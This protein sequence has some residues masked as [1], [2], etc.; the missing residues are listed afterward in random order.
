MPID[1]T[2]GKEVLIAA[3]AITDPIARSAF[4][5]RQCDAELRSWVDELLR[6]SANPASGIA[7]SA[8]SP[9]A[10]TEPD[11]TILRPPESPTLTFSP[12]A[13][14]TQ[15]LF[16]KSPGSADEFSPTRT[17]SGAPPNIEGSGANRG[18]IAG[19]YR[20]VE[21]IGQGGMGSVYLARQ[22]T[23][24]KRDVALKLIKKGADSRAVVARFEAER[25]ALALMDH[26]NIAS[27]YDGG[28]T[29]DG[30]P[31]FVMELV[32]GKPITEYCDDHRLTLS[33]R[34][35]L[36]VQVCRAVQHAHQKGIIHRDLKPGNIL[37]TEVD[38]RPTPKVIDFG[39]AKA[40]DQRL[41]DSSFSDEGAIVGTPA[42]MSP[43]QTDPTGVDI[44]T[45]TDV[46]ALGVVL[47]ELLAGSPPISMKDFRRG[48]ILEML[49]M[50]REIEPE[51]LSTKASSAEALPDIAAKRG[52]E[53]ARLLTML[54]GDVD[55]I[56]LKALEKDRDR[57]YES[58]NGMAAD[59]LRYLAD[60][61]I[62][63]R[64]PTRGYRLKKFIRRN[65]G[66]VLASAL[67][68][69]ALVVGVIGVVWQWRE[70]VHQRTVA[71]LARIQADEQR[72][73]AETSS[74]VA[75][76][77]RKVALEAVGQMVTTVRTELSK[78]PDL[79]GVLKQVLSIAQR[80][81]DNIAQNPLVDISL[82]DTTRAAAHDATAR[83]HRDTG[84]T[85]AALKE[86]TMAADIYRAIL[87]RAAEGPD[88][89]VVKKN[90][91]IVWISLGE[92]SL[93]TGT[94]ADARAYYEKAEQLIGR[95][96]PK[97]AADYRKILISLYSSLGAVTIDKQPREAR[98]NYLKALGIAGEIA[99]REIAETGRRSDD[100]SISIV[101]LYILIGG[102]GGRLRDTKSRES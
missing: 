21:E 35:E 22:S 38:G 25:Q 49:R 70:A 101:Q 54:R 89:E 102:A 92:T 7:E 78:K 13:N 73:L 77:Q 18:L 71:D 23:P 82:N 62:V 68:A 88:K 41:T 12:D 97:T 6:A 52:V 30:Q 61:P 75:L 36:F 59:I 4:L 72:K 45:R 90:L 63:A 51:H 81:L 11:E 40:I 87:D 27:V 85:V 31:Y 17:Y 14:G 3:L 43:E 20:I 65:R 46:Y 48:A 37:V 29:P 2:R 34:L 76:E 98:A 96:D 67:I 50:V 86:F 55:W 15:D 5:D 42:Y 83:M 74:R 58:A 84:D 24:V 95:L 94:Q 9:E 66:P 53:P 16:E 93:R 28:T 44:D 60:E 32:R 26:P 57:R 91:L 64:P 19:R 69:L 79:Q 10:V 8:V 100:T 99:D 33:D 1:P 56:V 47:Y 80:S 39:V